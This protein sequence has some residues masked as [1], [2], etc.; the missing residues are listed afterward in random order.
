M[1]GKYTNLSPYSYCAENPVNVIDPQGDTIIVSKNGSILRNDNN[2]GVVMLNY[3]NYLLFL[4]RLNGSVIIDNI[5][6]KLILDHSSESKYMNPFRL[7]SL[8]KNHGEWDLKNNN[9]TIWGLGNNKT[10]FIF[11][12]KKMTS[13]DI[14]NHHFGVVTK[15]NIFVSER[16]ALQ[17]AGEAQ[18]KAGTSLP[19]WQVSE[20]K[21]VWHGG[22]RTE[23]KY[24]ISPFGDDPND[25]KWIIKG[26]NYYKNLKK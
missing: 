21:I 24:P 3:N 8:V 7:R 11:N 9:G 14:G 16:F 4:G 10:T 18:I 17:K 20:S 6:F 26:F 22:Y 15:A 25:Q 1:A 5:Y 12:G 13:A 19:E 23:I 2:D